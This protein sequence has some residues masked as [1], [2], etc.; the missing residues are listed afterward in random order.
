VFDFRKQSKEIIPHMQ[1]TTMGLL[2]GIRALDRCILGFSP[3]ELILIGARPRVGK[4]SILRDIAL[5]IGKTHTVVLFSLEMGE[6]ELGDLFLCNLAQANY[7]NIVRGGFTE[8][9]IS[10]L[11]KFEPQLS[12]RSILVEDDSSMTPTKIRS[13][14]TE[15]SKHETVSCVLV[16]YIQLMNVEKRKDRQEEIS[17]VS[18]E[19]LAIAKDFDVPVIAASQLNRQLEYRESARPRL[20][21]LRES[22]ALEQDA[23]KVLL[24]HRPS[25]RDVLLDP[26]AEDTGEAEIIVVKNRKGPSGAIKCA[27]ISNYMSF[28]D[29]PKDF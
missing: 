19:L 5:S 6:K 29:I 13:A 18:R 11:A 10:H 20:C 23:N 24:L 25:C 22:G 9:V 26:D 28:Q 4:S 7:Y 15:L 1:D 14:L 27:F 12:A 8:E 17:I 21:D 16:D 2:S 3:G